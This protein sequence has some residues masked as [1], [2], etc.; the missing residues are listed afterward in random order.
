M[1]RKKGVLGLP[2]IRNRT[3][4]NPR[5]PKSTPVYQLEK[6]MGAAISVFEAAAAIRVPRKRFAPVKNTNDLMAVRSDRFSLNDKFQMVPNPH[7]SR[8]R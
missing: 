6:A 7:R 4:M 1:D 2:M 3:T 5:D 8:R